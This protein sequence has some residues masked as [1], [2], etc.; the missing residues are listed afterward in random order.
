MPSLSMCRRG[1]GLEYHLVLGMPFFDCCYRVPSNKGIEFHRVGQDSSQTN[2][3]EAI[4]MLEA[5]PLFLSVVKS[6]Q[7]LSVFQL[8]IH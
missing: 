4:S 7:L 3:H 5:Q 1:V 8:I 6:W 2:P